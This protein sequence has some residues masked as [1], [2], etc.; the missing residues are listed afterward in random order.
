MKFICG[1]LA[2]VTAASSDSTPVVLFSKSAPVGGVSVG[3][4]AAAAV[5]A[6]K[7]TP[8]AAAWDLLSV[9]LSAIAAD[10]TATRRDSADG[11]TR[12]IAITVAV[13]EPDLWV[14]VR[15]RIEAALAFLTT[16]LWRVTFIGGAEHPAA[17][18]KSRPSTAES[19]VLLS[20]GLDSLIGVI[21]LHDDGV[22]L[23]AVSH[24]VRG[25]RENQQ[26]FASRAGILDHL[27]VNHN[28]STPWAQKETSQRARSLLFLAFAIAAASATDKYGAGEVVPVYICENGF[29]AIN[30]P[31]TA[32]RVGSLSTR[33]AH[34]HFLGE[35]QGILDV[36]GLRAD[37]RNPYAAMTKGEMILGSKNPELLSELASRST[38]C[39]RY[40]RHKLQHCGRCV[41]CAV[42]RSAFIAAGWVDGTSYKYD[43]LARYGGDELEDP[44]AIAAAR[45]QVRDRGLDRWIGSSLSSPHIDDRDELRSMIGRGLDELGALLDRYGVS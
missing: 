23:L 25:D 42:R 5:R 40:Q 27:E 34:P 7:L 38:S 33:T 32:G 8:T 31:L 16:D 26:V 19:S 10:F 21:D 4:S 44:R 24:T 11:W 12:Q 18:K 14:S 43:D 28:V 3:G 30:P 37:L 35:L 17:P 13:S 20:G 45:V 6:R 22:P 39:G 2:V 9:A 1:P 29:I 15:P 36:L 41:P